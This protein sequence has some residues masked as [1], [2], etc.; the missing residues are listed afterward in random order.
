MLFTCNLNDFLSLFENASLI[1]FIKK[2]KQ[3]KKLVVKND[4]NRL[5]IYEDQI[6]KYMIKISISLMQVISLI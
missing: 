1:Q 6:Y 4:F 5:I 3:I 2:K